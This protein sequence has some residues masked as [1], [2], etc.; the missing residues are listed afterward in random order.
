MYTYTKQIK[1]QQVNTYKTYITKSK[2]GH[3]TVTIYRMYGA[4][5]QCVFSQKLINNV[6]NARNI[7][8]EFI[9]TNK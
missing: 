9:S 7:A 6:L 5:K 2:A 3:Y 4:R 1:V 8:N